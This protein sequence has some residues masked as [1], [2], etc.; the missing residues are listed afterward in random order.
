MRTATHALWQR[1][2]LRAGRR[3][4]CIACFPARGAVKRSQEIADGCYIELDFKKRHFPV[5]TPPDEQEAGRLS[6]RIVREGLRERYGDPPSQAV[7]DRLEHELGIICRMG[8]ASYFLIVGDFVR[9]A[10]ENGIPATPAARR[11]APWSATSS[12]SATLIR[13]NTICSS[14]ASSTPTAPRRP[15]STS[16]FARTAAKKSSPTSRANT[17][18]AAS[19]RSPRSARMAARAAIKDVGRV[20]DFPLER[21][22]QLTNMIP[23]TLG[24][25]LDEALKESTDSS[26]LMSP[27]RT[28]AN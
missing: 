18:K 1:S 13:W 26:R 20:L 9:F 12:N 17:A 16:T 27:T 19:R 8:F 23:K 14:S 2:V 24:V 11:A 7:K 3:K 22:T 15:T 6:A 21:V 10:V 25:T 5:F 28:S 4:R